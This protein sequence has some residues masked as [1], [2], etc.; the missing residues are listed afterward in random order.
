MSKAR[1][2]GVAQDPLHGWALVGDPSIAADDHDHVGRVRDEGPES[3]LAR[4]QLPV[5]HPLS[6]RGRGGERHDPVALAEE[7]RL[8]QDAQDQDCGHR[9]GYGGAHLAL[10]L[11]PHDLAHH[12]QQRGQ[13][14]SQEGE[15]SRTWSARRR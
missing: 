5:E 6:V 7:D 1:A 4:L 12:P 13:G 8:A 3:P 15:A 14:G 10:D 11:A 2:L 9:S